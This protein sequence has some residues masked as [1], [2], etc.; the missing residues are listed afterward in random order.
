M[1][2]LFSNDVNTTLAAAVDT[3]QTVI[4]V[5]STANLPTLGAGDVLP[6]TLSD[7]ATH[8]KY[9]VCYCTSISGSDLTVLRGMEGTSGQS[10]LVNDLCYD[11]HTAATT[12]SF[13]GG[14]G[15]DTG[16]ANAY[17]VTLPM[18]LTAYQLGQ[19]VRFKA[20]NPNTGASTVN[21]N[22][23]GVI[24]IVGGNNT[25][26]QGGE[27]SSTGDGMTVLVYDGTN[28]RM[29]VSP[30]ALQIAPATASGQAVNLGQFANTLSYSGYQKLPNGL[31][32]QWGSASS[33]GTAANNLTWTFPIAFP[34]ATL[35]L[36]SIPNGGVGYA[37]TLGGVSTTEL[38]GNTYNTSTLAIT[39]GIG[40]FFIVVGY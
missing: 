4:S 8:T 23:L 27:I 14:W 16:A 9:E 2:Y 11:A 28:F 24:N 5:A 3:T 39:S 10:W 31:I 18:T 26:L 34:N 17:V 1:S 37:F 30:G 7:A 22:G 36:G 25:A 33:S 40:S 29:I 12:A 15:T 21:V 13:D 35:S 6:I 19:T 32:M 20:V 38:Y